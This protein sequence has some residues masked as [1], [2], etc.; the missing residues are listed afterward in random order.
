MYYLETNN[1][2]TLKSL[3]NKNIFQACDEVNPIECIYV[4]H[5]LKVVVMNLNYFC[6]SFVALFKSAKFECNLRP[7]K[8]MRSNSYH[9]H[10][11]NMIGKIPNKLKLLMVL[12]HALICWKLGIVPGWSCCTVKYLTI[13]FCYNRDNFA[14]FFV[15][16]TFFSLGL[17]CI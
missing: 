8:I 9:S 11:D 4:K 15:Q 5:P 2:T 10:C 14:L 12:N 17:T 7:S 13:C 3:S 6:C 16:V 1:R